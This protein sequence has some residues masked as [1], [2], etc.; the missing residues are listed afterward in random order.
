VKAELLGVAYLALA[1]CATTC[2]QPNAA[3][4]PTLLYNRLYSLHG[5]VISDL[6]AG[7]L[8]GQQ[9]IALSAELDV[10]QGDLGSG[11]VPAATAQMD[12][13]QAAIKT[14]AKP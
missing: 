1:G 10:A 2:P 12:A 3:Q 7:K 4:A 11:A 8:T 5:T 14:E 13:V 6:A 9:A